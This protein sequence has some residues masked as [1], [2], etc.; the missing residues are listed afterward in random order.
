MGH[1]AKVADGKVIDVIRA[2]ESFFDSFVDTSAGK[3]I[4]TSYNT[5]EGEHVLGGTPIR[6]NFAGIGCNYDEEEDAFYSEPPHPSWLLD[7]TTF[8]W[9]APVD[10]PKDGKQYMWEESSLCWIELKTEEE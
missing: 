7:K 6:Y 10:Y 2:E 9:K 8:T 3:W 1:Y 4:K 5:I